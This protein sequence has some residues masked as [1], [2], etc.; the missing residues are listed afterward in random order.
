MDAQRRGR[1]TAGFTLVE[2]LVVILV[3]ALLTT[4]LMPALSAV[5]ETTRR[6]QC[7]SNLKQLGAALL[8]YHATHE[9][10][11]AAAEG[12]QGSVYFRHT[13]YARLYPFIEQKGLYD[14]FNFDTTAGYAGLD[15]TWGA[16]ENTTAMSEQVSLFLCPSN[17][18]SSPTPC[19]L[20]LPGLNWSLPRAAVTDYL[21]CAGADRFADA[22]FWQYEKAG[23][24]GFHSTTR[25]D[26]VRDGT[27]RTVLMGESAGGIE[28]NRYYGQEIPGDGPGPVLRD[29]E[30][31]QTYR[32][33]CF[34]RAVPH[35]IGGFPVVVDNLMH[36]AYGR[37]RSCR[38]YRLTVVGGLAARSTDGRGNFYPPNDCA[39]ESATDLFVPYPP[40]SNIR[41]THTQS[42]PNFRGVHPGI[43]HMVFGDG[44]VEAVEDSVSAEVFI[45]MTTANGGE[46]VGSGGP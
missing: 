14:Q 43:V 27:S 31:G 13:G 32:R 33:R 5:V 24:I 30:T 36:Q 34:Q 44:H 16:A 41:L 22:R 9:V 45:A 40:P 17:S 7:Q 21:F 23:A 2:L 12:G 20:S 25:L 37:Q 3:V 6:L 8:S 10:L 18:R 1:R 35:P 29:T 4:L 42:L 26:D 28:A 11:P 39:L 46:A 19:E 38:T 15:Y